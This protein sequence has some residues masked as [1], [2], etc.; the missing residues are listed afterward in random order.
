MKIDVNLQMTNLICQSDLLPKLQDIFPVIFLL[1]QYVATCFTL[2][3]VIVSLHYIKVVIYTN[4][5][6]GHLHVII[7]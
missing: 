2:T 6:E 5:I 7:P 3:V 4:L 1:T